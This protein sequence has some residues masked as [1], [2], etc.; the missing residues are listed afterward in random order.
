M[1][2]QYMY[3]HRTIKMEEQ[4][5]TKKS[6][7]VKIGTLCKNYEEMNE[8]GKEK[9]KEISEKIL[10]IYRTVNNTATGKVVS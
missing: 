5:N 6:S 7:S 3:T 10:E 8:A 2:R 1:I 9:L 4:Q